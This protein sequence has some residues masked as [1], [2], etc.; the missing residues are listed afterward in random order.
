MLSTGVGLLEG[1]LCGRLLSPCMSQ[2]EVASSEIDTQLRWKGGHCSG[3]VLLRGEFCSVYTLA[4]A[5]RVSST[6][7][8][9]YGG[10]Q[11]ACRQGCNKVPHWQAELNMVA[12]QRRVAFHLE[13][14]AQKE[15]MHGC[16]S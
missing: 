3:R 8:Q 7:C 12:I 6:L 4:L 1:L 9:E 5:Y 2:E 10:W 13:N 15:V 16:C 11:A 14:L